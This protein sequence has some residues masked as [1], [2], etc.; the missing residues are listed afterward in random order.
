MINR[1][2]IGGWAALL[3][4]GVAIGNLVVVFGILGPEVAGDPAMIAGLVA[5]RPA[6]L[7]WLEGFKLV[8]AVVSL[9]VVWALAQRLPANSTQVCKGVTACGVISALLLMVAGLAGVVAVSLTGRTWGADVL[10]TALTYERVNALINRLGLA[11]LFCHGLWLLGIGRLV[12]K[13]DDWPV[14]LGYLSLLSGVINLLTF[15]L[16]PL[17]L[18]ALLS[19]LVWSL[20]LAGVWLSEPSPATPPA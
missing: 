17:A 3:N 16:P 19:G 12:R 18:L 14:G 11:A 5:T 8:A 13:T 15:A 10:P 20:W 7:L 2:R 9:V 4:V 6:P 1:Q